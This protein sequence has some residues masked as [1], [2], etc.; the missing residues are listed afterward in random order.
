MKLY[1][2]E[3]FVEA[4]ISA[5]NEK[6][7]ILFIGAGFS[8]LCGLPLWNELANSLIDEC[9]ND[10]EIM[11]DFADRNI[12]LKD[13]D[14][15]TLITISYYLFKESGKLDRFTS[16]V[17][18]FLDN[19]DDDKTTLNRKLNLVRLVIE[20]GA[21]VLTTN[22]DDILHDCFADG[23]FINYKLKDIYKFK[24]NDQRQLLHLHGHRSDMSTM[25]YTVKD[26]LERY[27][28]VNFKRVIKQIFN[29]D[30]TIL[31]IGYGLN[32]MQL[33]DFLV[34]EN[35]TKKNRFVLDGF[36]SY[37]EADYNAKSYYYSAFDLSLIAYLKDKNNFIELENALEYLIKEAKK[38]SK[39]SPDNYIQATKLIDEKPTIRNIKIFY[40]VLMSLET[41]K[42]YNVLS[43]II[44]CQNRS[45]WIHAIYHDDYFGFFDIKNNNMSEGQTSNNEI[46][47][48]TQ[49]LYLSHEIFKKDKSEKVYKV[50]RGLLLKI[51]VN[52]KLVKYAKKD[53]YLSGLITRVIFS[54]HRLINNKSINDTF[55][56]GLD[57]SENFDE[58]LNWITYDSK[59]LNK[60]YKSRR[61]KI[62]SMIIKHYLIDEHKTY[63]LENY[64]EQY[65]MQ[66]TADFPNE[67]FKQIS[68]MFNKKIKDIKWRYGD[69]GSL[70]FYVSNKKG[71][72]EGIYPIM[73]NWYIHCLDHIDESKV[74]KV[75]FKY[76]NS[77]IE[78]EAK[79]SILLINIR[80]ELLKDAFFSIEK[81]PFNEWS[82]YSDLYQFIN[83]KWELF[84]DEEKENIKLKIGKMRIE[85]LSDFY[86]TACKLDLLKLI[87]SKKNEAVVK[88]IAY[89]I[90]SLFTVEEKSK[91]RQFAEP[92]LRNRRSWSSSYTITDDEDFKKTLYSLPISTFFQEISQDLNDSKR[93]TVTSIYIDYFDSNNLVEWIKENDYQ[94]LR[95]QND[96]NY[97]LII[98]YM[99][100]TE[101]MVPI[102][103]IISVMKNIENNV[104]KETYKTIVSLFV[105]DLY[106]KYIKK[107]K[108]ED[109]THKRV[110]D[111]CKEL[112]YNHDLQWDKKRHYEGE[113]TYSWFLGIEAYQILSLLILSAYH[114]NYDQITELLDN[115]LKKSTHIHIVKA[116]IVSNIHY[117]WRLVPEW[118]SKN[119]VEI[120]TNEFN[121]QNISMIAFQLSQCVDK[122]FID[123]ICDQGI[124]DNIFAADEFSENKWAFIHNLLVY[125]EKYTN[126]KRL[127][128]L[129]CNTKNNFGGVNSY[130]TEV[131]KITDLTKIEK[132]INLICSVLSENFVINT[133]SS[134]ILIKNLLLI[135]PKLSNKEY[136]WKFIM[137]IVKDHGTHYTHEILEALKIS[138]LPNDDLISFIDAYVDSLDDHFYRL[139]DVQKLI[140]YAN[141][142]DNRQRYQEIINKIGDVNPEFWKLFETK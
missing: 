83:L 115:E 62:N 33:L 126:S 128:E 20:S 43:S 77:N 81:N 108:N 45:D 129:I 3:D 10:D 74:N 113:I 25:V 56:V 118:V 80:F 39:I 73:L 61:L 119:L 26:Y 141:W 84:N 101:K 114:A 28:D 88:K 54:D 24:V 135:Y 30:Y 94:N 68:L 21:T 32:E 41:K 99:L 91:Y 12:I 124:I 9:L 72:R 127:L 137:F 106:F 35:Y 8:K 70:I 16:H 116:I 76:Y 18:R 55:V 65:G 122:G 44:K 49:V 53:K 23:E 90:E 36:F 121:G 29:S 46:D 11:L 82:M 138:N 22:S 140:V 131:A 63:E 87:G 2:N 47:K 89:T 117:L 120:F 64:L 34:G 13:K 105:T 102:D 42:R 37:E 5:I 19:F 85:H 112:Y 78:I 97:K 1:N 59:E 7:L 60:S 136:V 93:H 96:S 51:I 86:N 142:D 15:K 125:I 79:I 95:I 67:V 57:K 110:L 100:N 4:I 14:A 66:L 104:S 58:W 40:N 133:R 69:I 17:Y 103:I 107:I 111:F 98:Q 75:F 38:K 6:K 50:L 123:L 48:I 109:N 52:P 139:N 132:S 130:F 71:F 27:A 31:F 134:G 92:S